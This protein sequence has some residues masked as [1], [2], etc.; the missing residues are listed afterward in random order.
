MFNLTL[1]TPQKKIVTDLE[2]EE[3]SVPAYRGELNILPG[4]APLMSTLGVG[5]L[6]YRQKG[7][8]G[9][10]KAAISWGYCEVSPTGVNILAE[11]AETKSDIDFDRVKSSLKKAEEKLKSGSLDPADTV[12]YQR[13]LKRALVRLEL[14]DH[15]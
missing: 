10:E 6:R 15:K 8:S 12:K 7:G 11:T 1:V 3:V 5:L 9:F 4:H 2:I 14:M 13:K